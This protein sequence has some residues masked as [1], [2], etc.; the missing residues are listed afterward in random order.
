VVCRKESGGAVPSSDL[1]ARVVAEAA[2]NRRRWVLYVRRAG[3]G[4]EKERE[5]LT[6]GPH[7]I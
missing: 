3:E 2:W 7:L 4:K 6:H 1:G 5:R